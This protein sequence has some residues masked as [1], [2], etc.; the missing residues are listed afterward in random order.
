MNLMNLFSLYTQ[1]GAKYD[2]DTNSF[3]VGPAEQANINFLMEQERQQHA[4]WHDYDP[5]GRGDDFL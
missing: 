3:Q 5:F 4:T 1:S 2:P